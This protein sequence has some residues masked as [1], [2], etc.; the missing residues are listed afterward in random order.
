MKG[1]LVEM[2][3]QFQLVTISHLPIVFSAQ[4][5][6]KNVHKRFK[7][8]ANIVLFLSLKIAASSV[9]VLKSEYLTFYVRFTTRLCLSLQFRERGWNKILNSSS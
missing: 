4:K 8:I 7:T 6:Q 1:H 2:P 9:M 5:P 3:L